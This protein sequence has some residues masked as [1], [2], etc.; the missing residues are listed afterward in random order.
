MSSPA[1]GSVSSAATA[2]ARTT[3]FRIITGEEEPDQG[4]VFKPNNY[5]IGYLGQHLT[6]TKPTVLEEGCQGLPPGELGAEWKVEKVLS[7]L[8][9]REEGFR[10]QPF[11]ISGV[12]RCASP[13]QR[14]WSPSPNMLLLDGL[15]TFSI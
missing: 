14:S 1:K 7:G 5:S 9:F 15:R 2:T 10:P 4:K 12:F 3:L 6:F 8:G 13:W 11:R